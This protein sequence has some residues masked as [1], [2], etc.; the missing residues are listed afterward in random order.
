MLLLL[1]GSGL[2]LV[3]MAALFVPLES[4]AAGRLVL[5]DRRALWLGA[6]LLIVDTQLMELGGEPVLGLLRSPAGPPTFARFVLAFVLADLAGYWVHRTMHRIPLLWRFHALH[7]APK[8]AAVSWIDAWR[9]HPVD[10]L[11]HGLAVGIPGALLGASLGQLASVVLLR[12]AFTTLLHAR[13]NWSF[14]AVGALLASPAFH[15]AHHA[16]EK[17]DFDR[18]FGGTFSVWDRLFSTSARE[19]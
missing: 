11:L 12:K 16:D 1:G 9:Q 10:F 14:G 6:L 18:N 3:M 19:R 8:Q 4:F 2:F 7:H 5:P 13:V 17:A 15:R